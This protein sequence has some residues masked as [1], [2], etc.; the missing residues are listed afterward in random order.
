MTH[1]PRKG[2][3]AAMLLA[4][5]FIVNAASGKSRKRSQWATPDRAVPQTLSGSASAK[6]PFSSLDVLLDKLSFQSGP[7]AMLILR[8]E[9]VLYNKG[10]RGAGDKTPFPIAS[11]SKWLISSTIMTLVDDG[12]ISLDDS[13]SRYLPSFGGKKEGITIRHLLTHTSGLPAKERH[14]GDGPLDLEHAVRRLGNQTALASPPGERF[15]YGNLSYKVAVRIVEVVL[16]EPWPEAFRKRISEPSDMWDTI[17]P[18]N[19]LGK[20]IN[21]ANSTVTDFAKFLQMFK[22][23]GVS[24]SGRRVLSEEAVEEM[25][26][27]QTEGLDMG[28]IN[29]RQHAK[30]DRLEYGLGL[31]RERVDPIS[32]QPASISHFGTAGFRGVINFRNNYVLVLGIKG[33]T[34][35]QKRFLTRRYMETLDL[36]DHLNFMNR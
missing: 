23:N 10:F 25:M 8:D 4:A 31:W 9:Q 35:P 32:H 17:F 1:P 15:C 28:C 33:N 12:K 18:V 21:R 5:L 30:M 34:R 22:N 16:D 29:R 24:V 27:N 11:C 6:G 3:V 7:L 14:P 36:V 20:S 13:V 2:T 26:R 19:G